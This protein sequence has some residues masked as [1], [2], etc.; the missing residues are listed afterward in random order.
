MT[1]IQKITILGCIS[2]NE[3]G[4]SYQGADSHDGLIVC[5]TLPCTLK[6][7]FKHTLFTYTK[8]AYTDYSAVQAI[9]AYRKI[10]TKQAKRKTLYTDA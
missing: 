4:L 7:G 6:R 9:P 2:R 8:V 10:N 1:L 5:H 3:N